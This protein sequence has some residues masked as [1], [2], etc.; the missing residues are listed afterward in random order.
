MPPEFQDDQPH[1]ALSQARPS[2]SVGE[3]ILAVFHAPRR[4]FTPPLTTSAWVVPFVILL[5]LQISQSVLLRDLGMAKARTAIENNDR[6]P[7]EQKDRILERMEASGSNPAARA[8][9]TVGGAVTNLLLGLLLPTLLYFLGLNFMLG[10]KTRFMEVFAVVLLA[11]LVL[12][13]RDLLRI[14]LMLSKQS[15][16][17]YTS[18][19]AFVSSGSNIT[20]QALNRFD[21]FDLYRLFLITIGF[22][23]LT[24]KPAAR[25]VIPVLIVW[26]L[27]WVVFLGCYLSP[28]GQFMP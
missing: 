26:V 3:R 19:A 20:I 21:I 11:A 1:S 12:V 13:L 28:L 18:P 22:S 8:L 5:A 7:Q 6:I 14:P 23:V 16:D 4:A 25:T 24:G 10:A 2:P 9:Q 15:L 17:V 27:G